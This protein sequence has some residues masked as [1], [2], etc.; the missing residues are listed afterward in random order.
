MKK[1]RKQIPRNIQRQYTETDKILNKHIDKLP[2]PKRC[3]LCKGRVKWEPF[4]TDV[5]GKVT[6]ARYKCVKCGAQVNTHRGGK[7]PMGKLADR[8]LRRLRKDSHDVLNWN[9]LAYKQK[10]EIYSDLAKHFKFKGKFH[11]GLLSKEQC[12]ELIRLNK[13]S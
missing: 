3:N 9:D 5:Y 13:K 2:I 6:Q 8:E 1:R 7:Y 4:M 12:R 10:T 11:I